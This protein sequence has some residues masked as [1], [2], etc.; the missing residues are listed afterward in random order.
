MGRLTENIREHLATKWKTYW[1]YS[2][3][4]H[5]EQLCYCNRLSCIRNEVF[6]DTER[7]FFMNPTND[8]HLKTTDSMTLRDH[9]L[10]ILPTTCTSIPQIFMKCSTQ[11]EISKTTRKKLISRT[12]SS[13]EPKLQLFK[14]T[15]KTTIS[16]HCSNSRDHNFVSFVIRYSFVCFFI[17]HE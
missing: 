9:S 6:H 3:E 4:E 14:I 1:Q 7:S 10:W 8:L 16:R 5:P 11:V 2:K 17:A 12:F 15:S 13:I